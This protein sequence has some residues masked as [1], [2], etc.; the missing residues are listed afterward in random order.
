M[1]GLNNSGR[2]RLV[3]SEDRV[4]IVNEVGKAGVGCG[5]LCGCVTTFPPAG[6]SAR[7]AGRGFIVITMNTT[8][9]ARAWC[10]V[11]LPMTERA[12]A[13]ISLPV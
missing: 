8:M 13:V 11:A 10:A 3:I 9:V 5:I 7:D 12:S 4:K 6:V 1:A 2:F